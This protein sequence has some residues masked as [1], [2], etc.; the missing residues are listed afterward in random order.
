M[1]DS[2][3]DE[4]LSDIELRV[5][6]CSIEDEYMVFLLMMI[7]VVSL[8]NVEFVEWVNEFECEVDFVC[9]CFGEL[10]CY[11]LVLLCCCVIFGWVILC[12]VVVGIFVLILL[13][14]Y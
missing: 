8:G 9:V 2:D 3:D 7:G 13:L 4:D 12:V 5:C 11:L 10:I 1:Q 6:F 14:F